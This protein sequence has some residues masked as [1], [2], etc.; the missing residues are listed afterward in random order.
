MKAVLSIATLPF[1]KRKGKSTKT[2]LMAKRPQI[3]NKATDNLYDDFHPMFE[4]IDE[5]ENK[6]LLAHFPGM[7][8]A[9]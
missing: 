7:L 9:S 2:N 8:I 4:W 3:G 6:I 1:V 5:P